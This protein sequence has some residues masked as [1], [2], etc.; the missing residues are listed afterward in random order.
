V[1]VGANEIVARTLQVLG[2]VALETG[3]AER[4]AGLLNDAARHFERVDQVRAEYRCRAQ[5]LEL[6][7]AVPE[8]LLAALASVDADPGVSAAK[9]APTTRPTGSDHDTRCEAV[10]GLAPAKTGDSRAGAV[11]QHR[12]AV[13]PEGQVWRCQVWR[14]GLLDAA[15]PADPKAHPGP[16]RVS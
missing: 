4:A 7:Q 1:E 15:E 3:D 16:S 13:D 5:A 11:S 8:E 9:A 10:H 2:Q 6:Q 14:L 12:L